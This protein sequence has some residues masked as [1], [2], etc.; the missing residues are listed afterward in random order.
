MKFDRIIE[1]T[2]D[3]RLYSSKDIDID[4][5]V[6]FEETEEPSAHEISLWNPSDDTINRIKK[7]SRVIL[8][9][10]YGSDIG[11]ITVG[12]LEDFEVIPYEVDRE[13]KLYVA[14]GKDLLEENIKVSFSNVNASNILKQITPDIQRLDLQKDIT[15]PQFVFEGNRKS[16]LQR[17]S[18]ETDSK[19]YVKNERVYI[20]KKDFAENTGFLLNKDTG[21]LG[22]PEK[23]SDDGVIGYKVR[24]L[25]E[26]R[27]NTG[28]LIRIESKYVNGDFKVRKGTHT[29]DFITEIEVV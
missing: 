2:I 12:K 15:Y 27:I 20:V 28:V 9:C 25:L 8:A 14:D 21:L 4:F 19:F 10:G 5:F 29:S 22:F 3:D 7:G 23:F 17:L 26:H 18:K 13:L 24:C 1:L 11:A 16:A 6:E